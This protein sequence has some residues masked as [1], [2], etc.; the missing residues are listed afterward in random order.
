MEKTYSIHDLLR[1]LKKF[2]D[3]PSFLQSGTR[4]AFLADETGAVLA[5]DLHPEDSSAL[6]LS[7]FA[8]PAL[9]WLNVSDNERLTSLTLPASLPGLVHLDASQCALEKI[10]IPAD[11][12]SRQFFGEMPR[13]VPSLYLQKNKLHTVD[14]KGGCPGLELL[15][16]SGNELAA[17]NLPAGFA[18][19]AYL[20][21]NDNSD[22]AKLSFFAPLRQLDTL[23]LRGCNLEQ[24]PHQLLSF[25]SLRTL[26][27]HDNPLSG[28]PP[29]VVPDGEDENAFPAVR[30]Y[31][32]ELAKG[33]VI[34]ERVKIIVVGNGRVGKTSMLRRL[35]GEPFNAREF[36]THGV[37]LGHLDKDDLPDMGEMGLQAQVWDFG[38]QEIF[39]A[40]HQ[41]F[42]TEDALYILAW[43]DKENVL[44]YR[45][46]DADAPKDEARFQTREYWLENIRHRGGPKCPILMVQTHA[47]TNPVPCNA[48]DY[49][50]DYAARCLDFDAATDYG[51]PQLKKW[52]AQ[53]LK[54]EIPFFGGK[55]PKSY[56]R[57]I[58][59]IEKLRGKRRPR[60]SKK[61]F[62]IEVCRVAKVL[63]GN[64]TEALKYLHRTGAVVWFPQVE[65]LQDTVFTDP[66]WLTEQVYKLIN[67]EL[68]VTN[69]RF[70]L[71]YL[72]KHLPNFNDKER[73]QFVELLK[74]FGLIFETQEEGATVFI[75]PNYLPEE[76]SY[77]AKKLLRSHERV[78]VPAFRFAFPKFLP[79][80]VMVN[81]LSR[82]GPYSDKLYWKN[83][84]FFTNSEGQR[85][86]VK[87]EENTLEVYSEQGEQSYAL[88]AEICRAF[89]DLSGNAGAEL[90][91]NGR[92]VSWQMLEKA[93]EQKAE[94]A[95]VP[96]T[97]GNLVPVAQFARF[98]G[99]E[100]VLHKQAMG[101][102]NIVVYLS[103]AWG[104]SKESG[105]NHEKIVHELLAAL[106]QDGRFDVKYDK[107]D[108]DYRRSIREFEQELGRA[109]RIVVVLSDKYL[110]S[111]HCMFELLQI[112]RKSGSEAATF[113][114]KIFPIVLNDA[115]IH[116]VK[117]IIAYIKHW[118][119]NMEDL[120][121]DI[122]D[123]G[124]DLAASVIPD[125]TERK[126]IMQN[127]GELAKIIGDLNTF[128]P[129]SLSTDNFD[130][131]VLSLLNSITDKS[132]LP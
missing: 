48:D 36:Y 80:N 8:L 52:I 104:T 90:T 99:R 59:E 66:N 21:L 28:L 114:E 57:C 62:D 6:D 22:L 112:F 5:L 85:A 109:D 122:D 54:T 84:I 14:F 45:Q 79:D 20:Y 126:E 35:R 24:L 11:A 107:Q 116:D 37:R 89:V 65:L 81:F 93:N 106:E 41:F 40:T 129:Q 56:D 47:E 19:L 113:R 130:K 55:V 121:K 49:L 31:L 51:L 120:K 34:N 39:Y 12:F 78:L 10:E 76:L 128:N 125:F 2:S 132:P 50:K 118:K 69:G 25:D 105:E 115:K 46:R 92:T 123:I 33:D 64:E 127:I 83:G 74:T 119:D 4:N 13:T 9:Q 77:D 61:D 53:K 63:P 98:L 97:D 111:P 1:P 95:L 94:N 71:T 102:P 101:W 96:D 32:E 82:Y 100:G 38:G 17:L 15:D 23:H 44:M 117:S 131:I 124:W 3:W 42:L 75:A 87:L 68:A 91:V 27:L 58:G 108:V 67:N 70:D 73:K 103:Y 29:S 60:I 43:T 86:L 26:Y 88:Q 16:L 110:R 18:Q 30:A 7:P 72:E